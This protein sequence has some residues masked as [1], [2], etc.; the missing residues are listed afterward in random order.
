MQQQPQRQ[1]LEETLANL[2]FKQ[3]V[4]QRKIVR[5]QVQLELLNQREINRTNNPYNNY[6]N[7]RNTTSYQPNNNNNNPPSNNDSTSN[8]DNNQSSDTSDPDNEEDDEDE[9]SDGRESFKLPDGSPLYAGDPVRILNPF[10]DNEQDGTIIGA[11]PKR[12]KIKLTNGSIVLRQPENLE[13][14]T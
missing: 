10:N 11:T 4:F 1:I 5:T 2:E 7:L 13:R 12:L 3:R 14:R 6:L 9:E 8:S